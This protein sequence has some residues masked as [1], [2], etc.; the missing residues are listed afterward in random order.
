MRMT[1]LFLISFYFFSCENKEKNIRI[2]RGDYILTG[3]AIDDSILTGTINY[4]DS[5]NLLT[6]QVTYYNNYKQ[7]LA[8]NYYANGIK[9]DEVNYSLGKMNG[10]HLS[11]DSTGDIAYEDYYYY[12]KQIGPVY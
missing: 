10:Y 1:V 8:I 6:S 11:F 9:Q 2:K 3:H 12:G 7:G 5:S 4:Y